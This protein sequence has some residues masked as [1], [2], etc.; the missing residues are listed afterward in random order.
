[1]SKLLAVD[2]S[3]TCTGWALFLDGT[4]HSCGYVKGSD[5]SIPLH[6]RINGIVCLMPTTGLDA[7]AIEKPQIYQTSRGAGDPNKIALGLILVGAILREIWASSFPATAQLIYPA[8]WK[9]QVPKG[10]CFRRILDKLTA[11][12]KDVLRHDKILTKK[13]GAENVPGESS[14]A[15]NTLDAVGIGLYYLGRFGKKRGDHG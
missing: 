10:V 2:P 14:Q 11:A 15:G 4:L 7:V 9:G 8:E 5:P 1:M 6:E 12:E 3:L 13:G